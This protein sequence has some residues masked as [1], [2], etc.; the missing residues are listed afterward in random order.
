VTAAAGAQAPATPASSRGR[1]RR[2][3]WQPARDRFPARPGATH[4]PGA[5]LPRAKAQRELARVLAGGRSARQ[6][7]ARVGPGALLDWLEDQPGTTWQERWLASGADQAGTPG[8]RELPRRWLL[9]RGRPP[10]YWLAGMSVAMRAAAAADIVRPSMHWLLGGGAANNHFTQALAA[11]RDPAGFARL[12]GLLDADPELSAAARRVT[13]HR[14]A[15][16]V[17]AK[18]GTLGEV[19]IGDLLAEH[20]A[21]EQAL[22]RPCQGMQVIYGALRAMGV[23]DG[24]A[25]FRQLRAAGPRTPEQMID[26]Y[27]LACQPVRDLLVDYL[28][29]RQ[30]ALDHSTLQQLG[31]ELGKLFWADIEQH[32][33]GIS[34]IHLP[35]D[36]ARAWKQR[37][38]V[39]DGSGGAAQAGTERVSARH[40][41]TIVRAFYLDIAQWAL[42]DPSRWAQWAVPCPVRPQEITSRKTAQHRKSRMDARTRERLPVLPALASAIGRQR[43]DAAALLGAARQAQPGQEFTAAGR[44]LVR[45]PVRSGSPLKVWARDPATGERAEL[46]VQE[47]YAF[48]AWAATEVLRHT[49]IRIEELLEISHHSLVQYHLPGTRELVPLLQVTPSKTDAERLLLISP[50]L[51]DVLAAIISRVRGPSGAIPLVAAY[52][53][54]E[55]RW[56]PPAPLLF[57]RRFRGYDQ[58]L[59][60]C[61]IRDMLAAAITRAGIAD[62]ATG[63]PLS[64]TPHDFRRM[65]I[66]DAVL[67]GLPP[68]IAQVIAG[69]RDINVTM[70]YKAVYPAEAIQAHLAHLARRRALRPSEEYRAPTDAEWQQFLGHFERRKVATGTCGRAFAT[71]CPH[72][73]ACIRCPMLWPDPA[74]KHRLTEIRD[75][76]TARI[77]EAEREGWLG[78]I[79]GLKI[80]LAG[81]QDKLAQISRRT[82]HATDLGIPAIPAR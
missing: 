65:F 72:E 2:S 43:K 33:P 12:Q 77:T 22:R 73:H 16:I 57:Q 76:L 79:E 78:E 40:C 3:L 82:S 64:Y 20:A 34:T 5:A 4:W 1:D 55:R 50:D 58:A 15:V 52:D 45:L 23:I 7:Y 37:L 61:T 62:P 44:T 81:A 39:K 24:P 71:P 25:A 38:Q 11:E 74:Q 42:D 10:A 68:H 48:W 41:L 14:A 19:T 35:D 75:N 53:R 67:N 46:T 9:E 60:E 47:S 63:Q 54:H 28:R 32:H 6:G 56:L 51:A 59:Q 31:Y 13:V 26:R 21:E 66:T 69:H 36:V 18:G 29:E 80:S 27:H 70:G 49:G 17:A 8:W 30:P